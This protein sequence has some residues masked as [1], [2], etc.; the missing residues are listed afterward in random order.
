MALWPQAV[1]PQVDDPDAELD[2]RAG[3][4]LGGGC[5]LDRAVEVAGDPDDQGRQEGLGRRVV[6]HA[7]AVVDA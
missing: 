1:E 7:V 4:E 2:A 6:G 3:L 5:G